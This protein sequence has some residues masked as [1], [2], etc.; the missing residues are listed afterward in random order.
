MSKKINL[1]WDED[2]FIAGIISSSRDYKIVFDINA[3][4]SLELKRVDDLEL[5]VK[6]T[7]AKGLFELSAEEANDQFSN[8]SI[9]AYYDDSTK[10]DLSV[11][12]NLGTKGYLLP[13]QK[14]CDYFFIQR[15][16][17]HNLNEFKSMIKMMCELESISATIFLDLK[18]VQSKFNLFI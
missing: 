16:E 11:I 9:F 12:T 1:K 15:A 18:E 7:K 8:H 3:K 5:I 2:F 14:Q 6:D 10:K 4:F 13:E 17:S